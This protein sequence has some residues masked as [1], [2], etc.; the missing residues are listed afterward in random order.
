MRHLL[1]YGP[2]QMSTNKNI[3]ILCFLLALTLLSMTACAQVDELF[4]SAP[5]D[6]LVI[7]EV[8]TSNQLSLQDQ[9]YG[10]PDWIE[11]CNI[12][13]HDLQLSSFSITDN[14]EA[15]QKAF[16]LP[17]VILAPGGFY[18]LYANKKG[19]PDSLGFSLKKSG[20]TLTILDAHMEEVSSLIV[21]AL[22]RD[23]SYA[24]R[25]DGSYGYCDLPTPGAVNGGNI[26]DTLPLSSQLMKEPE[27]AAEESPR[28]PTI[29]ITEI[30]SRNKASLAVDGCEGCTEWI[31]L[32]NPNDVSVSLSGFTLTD[33]MAD[34]S[35][36]NFPEAEILPGQYLIVCCGRKACSVTE[37]VRIDIGLAA[38]GEELFLYDSNGY[39][40]DYV[41][42]PSLS[43]DTSW[44]KRSDGTWGYCALPTPG[45]APV[46]QNILSAAPS[47]E[48]QPLPMEDPFH[49]VY[50]HE[51][52]Y[53]NKKSIMDE[54]GDRSDF[55]ELFNGGASDVDL[56][57]WYLS[58][59]PEKLTKWAVPNVS[60][61]PGAYLLIFLSGKDRNEGELHASFSLHS[62]ETL[63]LYNS[64]VQRYDS[65]LIQE[66]VANV[67]IGRND[68]GVIVFYS[69]PT[70]LEENGNP[71]PTGK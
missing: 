66:T 25:P 33:T 69:H 47:G 71:L 57:G 23:V 53:R 54:D 27:V 68:A 56:G 50:I 6:V 1:L 65:I 11:L 8:V 21:P 10:S 62:G 51:V 20:E 18:L 12:S 26:F 35:M 16:R 59:D 3:R 42:F 41:A 13:D 58:D 34:A 55:V 67:S 70:P 63:I 45:S 22:I 9:V 30:V 52:L 43:A 31:E 48:I 4:S 49:T 37:H 24:R 5:K 40:L 7:N 36:Q 19:G 29:F 38:Q 32:F 61:A 28:S 2:E 39:S 64:V 17:D 60:L 15:P 14:L 46:D 44:A